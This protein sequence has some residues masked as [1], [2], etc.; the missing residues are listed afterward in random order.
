MKNISGTSVKNILKTVIDPELGINIVDLGLVYEVKVSNPDSNELNIHIIMTLTTPG[1][2]LGGWFVK[3][4]KETVSA[5]AHTEEEN[6][7]VE[8]VFDPPWTV[9]MMNEESKAELGF[10]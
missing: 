4:I 6:V 3:Q 9:D 7:V 2:P 10:D 8:I 1:C 5:G